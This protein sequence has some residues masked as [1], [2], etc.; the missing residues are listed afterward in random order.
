[1]GVPGHRQLSCERGQLPLGDQ[2]VMS[3][4]TSSTR[5]RVWGR[6]HGWSLSSDS[7]YRG[8]GKECEI[9][10]EI[11]GDDKNGYHL[12][13][14]PDGFFTADTWCETLE[15]AIRDGQELFGLAHQDWKQHE[16]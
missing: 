9:K 14:S 11:Q 5:R 10:L 2:V 4:W 15:A 8:P 6:K 3:R 1:M 16:P 12:I 7:G 13:M